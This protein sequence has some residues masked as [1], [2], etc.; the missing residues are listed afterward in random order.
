[1]DKDYECYLL[2]CWSAGREP[3][4]QWRFH[5]LQEEYLRCAAEAEP[6]D[7]QVPLFV[8]EGL[9]RRGVQDR[10]GRRREGWRGTSREGFSRLPCHHSLSPLPRPGCCQWQGQAGGV[11]DHQPRPRTQCFVHPHLVEHED[12]QWV[13][14]I[15]RQ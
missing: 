6:R 7:V 3:V 12:R 13:H 8:L 1:M 14:N 4:G 11:I 15:D 9:R 5:L 2:G 10:S